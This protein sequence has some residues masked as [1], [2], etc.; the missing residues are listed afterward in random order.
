MSENKD[1]IR[2][3]YKG[4]IITYDEPEN[5]WRFELRGR[6]RRADSLASVKKSIDA[7]VK[8][9]G[10]PFTRFQAYYDAGWRNFQMCEVTSIADETRYG[11][12]EVW[13]YN[14]RSSYGNRFKTQASRIYPTD[15]NNA[16]VICE[17]MAI[18]DTIKKLQDKADNLKKKLKAYV[19]PPDLEEKE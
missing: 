8:E 12:A 2:Y 7:P 10:P 15:E 17:I 9:K 13:C 11:E 4:V 14:S 19:V 16:K 3:E 18:M 5:I 6:Q 1:G